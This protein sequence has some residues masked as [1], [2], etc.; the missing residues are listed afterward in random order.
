[1]KH[2]R[3]WLIILLGWLLF[4][5]CAP[6]VSGPE[7][8]DL[9]APVTLSDEM[10]FVRPEGAAGPLIAYDMIGG[11]ERFTLPAGQLSANSDEFIVVNQEQGTTQTRV[12]STITGTLER[13]FSLT[14]HWTLGGVSPNGQW[15]A[16]IRVLD[17]AEKLAQITTQ[18]WQ[19]EIQVVA[20]AD[21]QIIHTL[22]LNG[23]FE[24]DALTNNGTSLFLVQ[25]VPPERP[26]QYLVRLYDL[27]IQE[28]LA[29][30]IRD[31]RINDELMTGYAWGN[32]ADPQGT[33]WLTNYLNTSQ[34]NA[35]IHA[36]NLVDKWAYCIDLPSGEGDFDALQNYALTLSPDSRMVYAV[37]PALGLVAEVLLSEGMV[38]QIVEFTPHLPDRMGDEPVWN[39][40]SIS[41]E[42]KW[43]TFSNGWRVWQYDTQTKTVKML[44]L[45]ESKEPLIGLAINQSGE[46]LYLAYRDQPLQVM[47]I[48][49]G[50]TLTF[51]LQTALVSP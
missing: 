7:S 8:P 32:V 26:D 24:V 25:Y 22:N 5:A 11:Q 39:H 34:N 33:W 9:P 15:L 38:T 36:L 3:Q 23:H 35:F 46:R 45:P 49:T 19:T 47:M 16:L 21:G 40:I 1:M 29:E 44:P 50:E 48:A 41:S 12:F 18:V 42:G 30:P 10:M 14:G 31:K 17:E 20:A 28:L 2:T 4:A 51:P 27:S 13:Q 37:N 6:S 43:V